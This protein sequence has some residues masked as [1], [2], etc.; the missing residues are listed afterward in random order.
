MEYLVSKVLKCFIVLLISCG[1][2]YGNKELFIVFS[3]SNSLRFVTLIYFVLHILCLCISY[4][5]KFTGTFRDM[6]QINVSFMVSIF[7]YM[8][9][10]FTL[11]VYLMLFHL[12]MNKIGSLWQKIHVFKHKVIGESWKTKERWLHILIVSFLWLSSLCIYVYINLYELACDFSPVCK[13]LVSMNYIL[14]VISYIPLITYPVIMCLISIQ[15]KHLF[16]IFPILFERK[17]TYQQLS[18]IY[19]TLE[20]LLDIVSWMDRCLCHLVGISILFY[21]V[22]LTIELYLQVFWQGLLGYLWSYIVLAPFILTLAGPI[23]LNQEVSIN[24]I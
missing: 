20:D 10:T 7:W 5:Y 12:S 18:Y 6:E 16:Q 17:Y 3:K 13:Y 4:F 22:F 24:V 15:I 2:F 11:L 8:W 19:T 21:S 14:K 9:A 1:L 23:I